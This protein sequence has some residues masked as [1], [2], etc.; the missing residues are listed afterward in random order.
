M[1]IQIDTLNTI[2][3]H[4]IVGT[5][6]TASNVIG[7]FISSVICILLTVLIYPYLDEKFQAF[8]IK[9][10]NFLHIS[11]GHQVAGKWTHKW[12]VSSDSFPKVNEIRNVQ[13][14][15]FR[16]RIFAQYKVTD[17]KNKVY[18]YQ[19]LG[20]VDK[21]QVITGIWRDIEKGNRYHGCFQIYIDIN[22][23]TMNGYWTGL[24]KE[25]NIK[26]DRW[27]WIRE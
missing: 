18:T 4:S 26:S 21:D 7:W 12:H 2:E 19:M 6:F 27:E 24:S 3:N 13:I 25:K 1:I 16:K 10:F 9:R 20:K 22:E 5:T 15:Q 17:N 23:Q 14:K 11:S 8:V